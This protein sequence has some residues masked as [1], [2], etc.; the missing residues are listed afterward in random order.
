MCTIKVENA[1]TVQCDYSKQPELSG[2][3]PP[4]DEKPVEQRRHGKTL[5]AIAAAIL[6]L[7][8][9]FGGGVWYGRATSPLIAA[10]GRKF[11]VSKS[12]VVHNGNCRYFA[13]NQAR[14]CAYCGG[15]SGK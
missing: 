13:E 14:N 5:I 1:T 8:A 6:A 12:G 10:D 4:N 9:G 11:T 2:A 7:L 15:L 3:E